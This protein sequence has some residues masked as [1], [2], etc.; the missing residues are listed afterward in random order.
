MGFIG[1][2]GAGKTTTIKAIL[3][4][5]HTSS[6]HIEL[7][8]MDHLKDEKAIKERIGVVFADQNF[9]EDLRTKEIS[10]IMRFIYKNWD[11]ALFDHYIN[12]FNL[13]TNKRFKDFSKGMKMKLSIATAFAHHPDLLILDEATS[14]LDPVVRNEILDLFQEFIEDENHS[15]LMSSHITSDL[16]RIADYITFI[17][18]GKLL[19]SEPKDDL[20]YNY[21]IVKCSTSQYESLKFDNAIG[22]QSS[23]FGVEVL[24]KNPDVFRNQHK[25]IIV[26]PP[27]IEDI[28]LFH[29]KGVK[30]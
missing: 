16:D 24:I 30:K 27:T 7:L 20:I 1:E 19:F 6:G 12:R 11:D 21:G 18:N 22:F 8:G 9:P 15:I 28:M 13:P 14:G 3:N 29:I 17:H 5:I 23:N 26:D 25:D 10:K 2:N 4:Y